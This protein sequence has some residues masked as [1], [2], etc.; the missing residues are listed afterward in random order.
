MNNIAICGSVDSGKSSVISVLT[1]GEL[2]D[3][4]GK[5]RSLIIKHKHELVSG[6]TSDIGYIRLSANVF[7]LDLC[8]HETYLKSTLRGLTS[9][10]PSY[11][12]V[13]VALNKGINN[14]TCNHISVCRA[15]RIP[16]FLVFTK[17]DLA[18][19]QVA[20]ETIAAMS[21]FCK[22]DKIGIRFLYEIKDDASLKNALTRYEESMRTACPYIVISNKTGH[23]IALLKEFTLRLPIFSYPITPS[24]S[25]GPGPGIQ[26]DQGTNLANLVVFAASQKVTHLFHIYRTLLAEGFGQVLHGKQIL[27]SLKKGDMTKIGPIGG[28]F[29]DIK[30]RSIHNESR[31]DIPEITSGMSGCIA[32]RVIGSDTFVPSR[33]GLASGKV[34]MNIPIVVYQIRTDILITSPGITILKG[35]EPYL[36]LDIACVAGRFI[37]SDNFP[38]LNGQKAQVI[39][40]FLSPQFCYPGARL[41][42]RSGK[43]IG[44]GIV[45]EV[46]TKREFT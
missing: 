26:G 18:P 45:R 22:N 8:G 44:V 34:C 39:I 29:Y 43:I 24:P 27:G 16:V 11:A 21:S 33:R 2:D 15:L 28:R 36:H 41:I 7:L 38:V 37:Q 32:F 40:E 13:A 4:N 30:V 17:Q 3:G 19:P 23:G 5:A 31:E 42:I 14:V 1:T 35:F 20:K 25:P 46:F 6:R 9:Y 10:A 12:L